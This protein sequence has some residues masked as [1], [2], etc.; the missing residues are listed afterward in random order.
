MINFSLRLAVKPLFVEQKEQ[1]EP[2]LSGENSVNRYFCWEVLLLA[3]YPG[4]LYLGGVVSTTHLS[5]SKYR[6]P[7][8]ALWIPQH[9]SPLSTP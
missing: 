5:V 8:W 6:C 9:S 2:L 3:S 4:S 7:F 1:C